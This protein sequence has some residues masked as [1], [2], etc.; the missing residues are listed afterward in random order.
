[1]KADIASAADDVGYVPIADASRLHTFRVISQTRPS[2]C[3]SS[4]V[5][6]E[7][8]AIIPSIT[9]LPKPLR[10]GSCTLGP[11]VSFQSKV[12]SPPGSCDHFKSTRPLAADKAPYLAALV[13]NSCK[14]IAMA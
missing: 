14:A 1:S 13:A 9:R 6:P 5:F 7:R 2:A 8:A 3:Q 12:S 10:V 4:R 11:S